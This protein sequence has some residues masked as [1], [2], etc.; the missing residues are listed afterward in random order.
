[1]ITKGKYAGRDIRLLALGFVFGIAGLLI[2]MTATVAWSFLLGVL[3]LVVG[4][5]FLTM[6]IRSSLK[7]R[8]PGLANAL[9]IAMVLFDI[10]IGIWFFMVMTRAFR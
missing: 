7:K 9:L 1:M 5:F 4:I 6:G 3:A 10:V 8:K 2:I